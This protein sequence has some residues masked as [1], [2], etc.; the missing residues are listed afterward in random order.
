MRIMAHM[1]FFRT[2]ESYDGSNMGFNVFCI[3][4]HTY[5]KGKSERKRIN[6]Q[7]LNCDYVSMTSQTYII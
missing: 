4:G 5:L 6:Y 1:I 3:W 2:C 7:F